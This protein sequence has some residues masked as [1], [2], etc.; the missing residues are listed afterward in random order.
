MWVGLALIIAPVALLSDLSTFPGA[1]ALAPCFGAALVILA[2]DQKNA[3]LCHPVLVGV[4]QISYS[5]YLWHWPI[6]LFERQY[7]GTISLPWQ[8]IVGGVA[9]S[10]AAATLSWR[11]VEQP[12]RRRS[13][14]FRT[15][16]I[17]CGVGLFTVVALVA[18]SWRGL[19]QRWPPSI[20]ALEATADDW[21]SVAAKCEA[22]RI[23]SWG[24]GA[25]IRLIGD[26]HAGAISAAVASITSGGTL[27]EA[28]SCPPI[29][30]YVPSRGSVLER[31]HCKVRNSQGLRSMIADP[32]VHLI[33]LG[34]NWRRYG[35]NEEAIARTIQASESVVSVCCFWTRCRILKRIY[36]GLWLSR[37]SMSGHSR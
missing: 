28:F 25:G 14:P 27:Y 12:S 1:G 22:E 10:F 15:V 23:C 34:A 2:G 37:K 29:L 13:V 35:D 3:V 9:A 18:V 21:S 20:L 26:S 4:G 7:L 6:V 16:A 17:V 33:I 11:F 24:D 19:P 31:R 5:L 32:A 30:D 8:W 36:R